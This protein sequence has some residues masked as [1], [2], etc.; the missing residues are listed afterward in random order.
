[1]DR[2]A[3]TDSVKKY[4]YVT[5]P[6][7]YVNDVPHI[8][9]AYTSVAVDV[10]ARFKRMDGCCVKFLTGTD[11]H[12]QKIARAAGK[13]GMPPKDFCDCV[14]GNFR[15]LTKALH[16]SND[17]FIRTTE[18][19]HM[20]SAQAL[21]RQLEASG[22]LYQGTYAGWYSTRDEAFVGNDEVK[23][24][25]AP[26]GAP[27]EWVEEAGYFFRLSDWQDKLLAFYDAHPEF[28]APQSRR[29]EV[30][31]FVKSGLRDLSISRCS[32]SWGISVPGDPKHVMYVWIDALANYLSA[33]GYPETSEEFLEFWAQSLHVVGKDI[34]RFHAVYWPAFL[35]AAGLAPPKKVFAHG[36][37]TN[38]GQ[39]ISKSLGNVI[40]PHDL[41]NKYGLDQVRYFLMRNM[42]FGEDGNF[43]DGLITGRINS[44]LANDLGNT[45]QR[46]LT[47]VGK[48]SRDK[49]AYAQDDLAQEDRT[50]LKMGY[51]CLND[52]RPMFD[53]LSFEKV[54]KR[55]WNL[56]YDINKY[57]D[58]QAPWLLDKTDIER[59]K[60]V[61]AVLAEAVFLTA[62]YIRPFMPG[63]ADKIFDML[64]VDNDLRFF[65]SVGVKRNFNGPF[66]KPIALFP[67]M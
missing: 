49:I 28:I 44:D 8:G 14:S 10:I 13:A 46:V 27:V 34:I 41:M 65:K 36:W 2:D 48:L 43:S 3:N 31:S 40:D 53:E 67:R 58:H 7:Y 6:I 11:E 5:T 16:L 57:I 39:K 61:L 4:F 42:P 47:M 63:T 21:W 33:L 55:I 23:D 15:D 25:L 17:D 26:S 18:P 29:N 52:I 1:M 20:A 12:G 30:V 9:H 56:I 32:I 59:L 24:G 62:L 60:V 66:P 50:L 35:M 64:N 37:W 19:R 38:D 45:V 22:N 51:G 54:L